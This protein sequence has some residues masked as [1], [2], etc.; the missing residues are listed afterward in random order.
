MRPS[1]DPNC[2]EPELLGPDTLLYLELE[3]EEDE[4]DCELCEQ[5][6]GD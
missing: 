3:P 1:V 4:L 5:C 2:N 6:C